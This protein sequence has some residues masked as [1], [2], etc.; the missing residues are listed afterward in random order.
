MFKYFSTVIL[1]TETI[2]LSYLEK[3]NIKAISIK[4]LYNLYTVS[5]LECA[6]AGLVQFEQKCPPQIRCLGHFGSLFCGCKEFVIYVERGFSAQNLIK[7]GPQKSNGG[8][9]T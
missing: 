9:H 5:D 7:N 4:K 6:I 8:K 1:N 3:N 2:M